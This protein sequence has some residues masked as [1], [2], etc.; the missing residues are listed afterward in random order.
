MPEPSITL[1]LP[2]YNAERFLAE[3]IRSIQAQTYPDFLVIAVLDGCTD[4]SEEILMDLKDNRFEVVKKERNEGVVAASNLVIAK[5]QTLLGGRMDADDVMH[6][7]RLEKQVHYMSSHPEIDV[8]GTWFDYIDAEGRKVKDAFPFPATHEELRQAF[9]IR[10]SIGGPTVAFR[11]ERLRAIGGYENQESHAEDLTLWLKCLANGFR[12]ANLPE[13]LHH[14]RLSDVQASVR[15]QSEIWAMTNAMY[16]RYGRLIWGDDAPDY[17][18]GAP[19][20]RRVRRKFLR[21]FR[22][23]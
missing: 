15:N 23:K 14:Y 5:T 20:W 1:C 6:P 16:R 7:Q 8:L 9:R 12:L 13:V 17:E 2:I 18:L 11:T 21:M 22:A 3:A 4:R 19:L 10:N